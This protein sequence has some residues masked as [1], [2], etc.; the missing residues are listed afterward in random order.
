V[1]VIAKWLGFALVA[2]ALA[3]LPFAI[4]VSVTGG[5]V[6]A[7]LGLLGCALLGIALA[8]QPLPDRAP[9]E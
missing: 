4:W 9:R 3:V 1:L 6:S 2:G 7:A 8:R 5:F